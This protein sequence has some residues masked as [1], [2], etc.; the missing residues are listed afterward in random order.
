MKRTFASRTFAARAFWCAA[1]RGPMT[2]KGYHAV[3]AQAATSGVVAGKDFHA[4]ATIGQ[5][6]HTGATAGL[7]NG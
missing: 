6:H 2:P 1:I 3:E 5:H 7:C 4:G